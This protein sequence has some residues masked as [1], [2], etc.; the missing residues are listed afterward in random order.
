VDITSQYTGTFTN[1]DS[2]DNDPCG[3]LRCSTSG[4]SSSAY[5]YF[6]AV[7]GDGNLHVADGSPCKTASI[8]KGGQCSNKEC[9]LS[10]ALAP[11]A[12]CGNQKVEPGEEC[13]DPSD[14]CCNPSTCKLTAAA[15]C[16]PSQGNCCDANTCTSTDT[17]SD[18]CVN[19]PPCTAH[20]VITLFYFFGIN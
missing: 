7:D 13:D 1:V 20:R 12:V 16:S 2:Q 8:Q 15:T 4:A 19:T 3:T 9:V 5:S 18:E 10:A 11:T 6:P 14:K 17:C